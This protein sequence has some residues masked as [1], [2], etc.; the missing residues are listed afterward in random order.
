MLVRDRESLGVFLRPNKS[1]LLFSFLLK[2]GQ[3]LASD[4]PL[5]HLTVRLVEI[6][7]LA[8]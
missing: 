8:H 4:Y 6:E 5:F 2:T 1:V 3:Q 7:D